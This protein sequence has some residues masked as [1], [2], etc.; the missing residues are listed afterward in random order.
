VASRLA[1]AA[2]LACVALL[3][4]PGPRA[5]SQAW[6][7]GSGGEGAGQA[8]D[9]AALRAKVQRVQQRVRAM[10]A[11]GEDPR[12]VFELMKQVEPLWKQGRASEAMDR[13]D[14]ALAIVEPG[15]QPGSGGGA[16]TAGGANGAAPPSPLPPGAP[17]GGGWR[18]ASTLPVLDVLRRPAGLSPALQSAPLLN[19]N[20]PSVMAE[21]GR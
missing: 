18:H 5:R 11:R 10:K 2:L 13:V 19:W 6:A 3:A 9:P 20:D 1:L 15:Y 21:D 16:A 4:C 17:A 8:V 7:D 12:P 14:R